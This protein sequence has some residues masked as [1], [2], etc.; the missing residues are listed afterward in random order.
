MFAHRRIQAACFV[1]FCAPF[2]G[3][4]ASPVT[5]YQEIATCHFVEGNPGGSYPGTVWSVFY[6]ILSVDNSANCWEFP[7]DQEMLFTGRLKSPALPRFLMRRT[8]I[9]R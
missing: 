4:C 6:K 7:F 5:I 9:F 1:F 3:A 2:L 8:W